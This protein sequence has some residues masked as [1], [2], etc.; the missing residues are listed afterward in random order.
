[1]FDQRRSRGVPHGAAGRVLGSAPG[2]APG[3]APS[4][5]SDGASSRRMLRRTRTFLPVFGLCLAAAG[6]L[7]LC[8]ALPAARG[9][10]LSTA[11]DTVA[12][13]GRAA[14]AGIAFTDGATSAATDGPLDLQGHI[15]G[16]VTNAKGDG[17]SSIYITAYNGGGNYAGN[18]TTDGEG[19]YDL[20]GLAG[21]A[22]RLEFQD[23]SGGYLM[24]YYDGQDGLYTADEI[25]VDP[26]ATTAN[27]NVTMDLAG[28]VSGK[29]VNAASRGL[30]GI[31]VTVYLYNKY[32]H[33]WGGVSQVTTASDGTY[34]IGGLDTGACRLKFSD[35][36]LT[37]LTQYYDDE[38]SIDAAGDIAV[39]AGATTGGLNARLVPGGNIKGKVTNGSGTGLQNIGVTA[40]QAD[41][42]G[43][44]NQAADAVTTNDG[45]YELSGLPTGNYCLMLQDYSSPAIY[46]T[47]YYNNKSSPSSADLVAVTAGA[48]KANVNVTLAADGGIAGTVSNANS[49]P[50]DGIAVAAYRDNGLGVWV[51]VA[52]AR[53]AGHGRYHLD[54]LAAGN[55]RLRFLDESGTYAS[56]C[57][58][59]KLCLALSDTV[60]VRGGV[61]TPAVNAALARAGDVTG[62]VTDAVGTGLAGVDVGAWQYKGAA[63]RP[64]N[65]VK[66]QG[67]GT[68]DLTGLAPGSYRLEFRD[69]ISRGYA[70]QYYDNELS[71]DGADAVTVAAAATTAGIDATL[72]I[73]GSDTTAPTTTAR[74]VDSLWH[75]HAVTVTL[76]ATDNLHGSGV[77]L[78]EYR[79]VKNSTDPP[80]WRTYVAATPLVISAEG[81]TTY[82]YRSI[83]VIRNPESAKTFTVKIDTA[84]PAATVAALRVKAAAAKKGKTLKVKVSIADSKPGCGTAGLVLVLTGA[85]GKTLATL[86]FAGEPTDKPLSLACKLKRKLVKGSYSISAT[87]TDAAG[88]VQTVAGTAKLTIR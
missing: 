70:T 47:Q 85:R 69:D 81:T 48:T 23:D 55:Y 44:W 31:T 25:T 8:V 29:I 67:G 79:L 40:F 43:G 53:T 86:N 60:V 74:G 83:D 68:Y 14:L 66:T 58:N 9:A 46:F 71:L 84:P 15:T 87:A 61:T 38:P 27:I 65:D 82:Q 73:P 42:N 50:L 49:A 13:A 20:G 59:D 22:Y 18:V 24:Q 78:T 2:N 28:H 21:G 76:A 37:Y 51:H 52:D 72:R 30:G 35:D 56:E 1:M 7:A 10:S 6:L 62:T 77:G 64:V 45:S 34:D 39:V 54:G 26:G 75:N 16:T 17:L 11:T 63:W 36:S 57:Y 5:A 88:N 19:G 41:G 80:P 4:R 3:G 32:L 33:G 12:Q